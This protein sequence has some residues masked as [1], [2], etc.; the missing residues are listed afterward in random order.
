LS[1]IL[2]GCVLKFSCDLEQVFLLINYFASFYIIFRRTSQNL[3]V[4]QEQ[5][6]FIEEEDIHSL[7]G[8]LN[9]KYTMFKYAVLPNG[10]TSDCLSSLECIFL[11]GNS[12]NCYVLKLLL[13]F[14]FRRFQGTMQVAAVAFIMVRGVLML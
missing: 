10:F 1:W 11:M 8:T 5:L 4:L 12:R 9:T 6:S 2:G 14:S 7:H 3:I 13:L